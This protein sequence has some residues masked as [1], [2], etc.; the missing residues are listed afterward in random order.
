MKTTF[1]CTLILFF[2]FSLTAQ[3]NNK[4]LSM[5][6]EK[7]SNAFTY[8][9]MR[10]YPIRA[11]QNFTAVHKNIGNYIPLKKALANKK[12]KIT[13]KNSSTET[14]EVNTLEIQNLSGDS[15][16]ILGGEVIQGGKQDR[17][18]ASDVILP[19]FSKKIKLDV[20]C[21]E[22]GRW[23]AK[24]SGSS[25]YHFNTTAPAASQSVRK[26]GVINKNQTYVWDEV[27][28]VTKKNE[29]TSSTGSYNALNSDSIYNS[30][31]KQYKNFF[32]SR[33][34]NDSTII[35]MAV[36]TGKKILGCELFASHKMLEMHSS[37]LISSYATETITNGAAVTIPYVS[38]KNYVDKLLNE[39]EQDKVI[40]SNG[41]ELKSNGRKLH[42]ATY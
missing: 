28:T 19:P 12:V 22:H 39:A 26:A 23:S 34:K 35:G 1:V 6:S 37:D 33:L 16:I 14:A 11:N 7:E 32:I 5:I 20:F 24:T 31:I 15:V 36:V 13:E 25:A 10:I 8:G 29:C 42:I 21:V 17:M 18:I 27:S 40:K 2:Y 4:N 41:T 3:Y 9:N 30:K 38:V